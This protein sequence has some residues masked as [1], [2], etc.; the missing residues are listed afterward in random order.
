MAFSELLARGFF[1]RV[2]GVE[3]GVQFVLRRGHGGDGGVKGQQLSG[4]SVETMF[5]VFHGAQGGG[6]VVGINHQRPF[7]IALAVCAHEV[8]GFGLCPVMVGEEGIVGPGIVGGEELMHRD[9]RAGHTGRW[10]RRDVLLRAG[11]APPRTLRVG[12][13]GPSCPISCQHDLDG[14]RDASH[15]EWK[16][17]MGTWVSCIAATYPSQSWREV[18]VRASRC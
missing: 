12:S 6:I 18:I 4:N 8:I 16:E 10:G 3:G 1:E 5:E 17:K 2:E 14:K 11:D 15:V 13:L 9:N 7:A